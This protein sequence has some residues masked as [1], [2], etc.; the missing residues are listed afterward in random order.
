MSQQVVESLTTGRFDLERITGG[1]DVR[2]VS[3]VNELDLVAG[4]SLERDVGDRKALESGLGSPIIENER[5]HLEGEID[6][7]VNRESAI[8]IGLVLVHNHDGNW[9]R[10]PASIGP[11]NSFGRILN[12]V[13]SISKP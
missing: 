8:Q 10:V 3:G 11:G 13:Q 9:A 5:N 1:I 12:P 2:V 7:F 4:P 6:I